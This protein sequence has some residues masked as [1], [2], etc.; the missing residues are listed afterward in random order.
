[1]FRVQTIDGLGKFP[2]ECEA[3]TFLAEIVMM[4]IVVVD[5]VAI[6]VA[7]VTTTAGAGRSRDVSGAINDRLVDDGRRR[8]RRRRR[9]RQSEPKRM[10]ETRRR[11]QIVQSAA[12]I[13][14][15]RR[16]DVEKVFFVARD[17][18]SKGAAQK[19]NVRLDQRG[20]SEEKGF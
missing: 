11:H 8:G 18:G 9:S 3:E 12:E 15:R 7:T 5:V 2:Q 13:L 14:Q 17:G 6:T 16:Y 10:R 20:V 1:M 4:V 19:S